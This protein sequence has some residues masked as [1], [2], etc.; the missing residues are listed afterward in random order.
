MIDLTQPPG[1]CFQFSTKN[2]TR[3]VVK[4]FQG[5]WLVV[6]HGQC[7]EILS[8]LYPVLVIGVGDHVHFTDGNRRI[9]TGRIEE[10]RIL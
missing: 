3:T 1:L 9:V 6:K 4:L 8:I 10:T 2:T 7:P 5:N